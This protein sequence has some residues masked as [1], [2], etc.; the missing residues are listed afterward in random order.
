MNWLDPFLVKF[1]DPQALPSLQETLVRV[2]TEGLSRIHI[3]G[4]DFIFKDCQFVWLPSQ[5][6]QAARL[7]GASVDELSHAWYLQDTLRQRKIDLPT[8]SQF[9]QRELKWRSDEL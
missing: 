2:Q 1:R 8:L 7:L 3:Q 5:I 4:V 6:S 9:I